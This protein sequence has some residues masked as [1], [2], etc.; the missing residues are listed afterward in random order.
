MYLLLAALQVSS[1]QCRI[2][3]KQKKVVVSKIVVV[4]VV[5]FF[6]F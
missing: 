6:F 2:G 4:V 1:R 3:V 5:V